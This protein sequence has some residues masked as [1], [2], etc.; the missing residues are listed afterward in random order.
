VDFDR[1]CAQIVD[2]TARLVADL[3]GA[4][5]RAP[6]PSCP[7]WTLG[8]LVRH[9]GGGHRWAEEIVRTRATGFLPDA[10]LRVLDGDDT[11]PLPGGWLVEGA[12]RLAAALRAAGPGVVE[13][14]TPVPG[15]G[16]PFYARRFAHETAVHRAD[17]ALAAGVPFALAPEVAADGIDEWM[18][19]ETLPVHLD[20]DP[21]KRDV[22]GAGR[23]LSFRADSGE[24]WLLDA[25][26][27][28]VTWR[29][30][31]AD[32]AVTVRGSLTELL[33]VLYRRRAARG[34]VEVRGD[35]ALL[36]RYLRHAAF[37]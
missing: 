34:D 6:V 19:L 1:H 14:W 7:A 16:T 9:V 23:T 25:T 11:G 22:L 10:Q 27:E 37:G 32:A 21:A 36:D 35:R 29:R 3:A 8:M 24:A 2:Q 12:E 5:L 17:A 20:R 4:D 18:A 28:A 30:S 31:G 33:L 26:G 13:L 15:A